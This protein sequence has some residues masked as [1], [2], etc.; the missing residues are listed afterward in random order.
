[1]PESNLSEHQ[2]ITYKWD[3]AIRINKTVRSGYFPGFFRKSDDFQNFTS[4]SY[5]EI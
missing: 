3:S 4:L 1:M 2:L 5:T